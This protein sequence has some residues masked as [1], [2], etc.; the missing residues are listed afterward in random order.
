MDSKRID[1]LV[2]QETHV[3]DESREQFIKSNYSW[4]FSGGAQGATCYPG[5]AIVVKNEPRNFIKD[6]EAIDERLMTLTLTGQI[7]VTIV[8]AYA[9]HCDLLCK[10][11]RQILRQTMHHNQQI[12]K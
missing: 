1:I 3:G 2:I 5:V 8:A 9:P 11:Q 10:R 6:I 7:D 12:Q 4:C